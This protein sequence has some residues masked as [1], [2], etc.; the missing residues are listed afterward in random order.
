[1]AYRLSSQQAFHSCYTSL[2]EANCFR[3][4]FVKFFVYWALCTVKTWVD[5]MKTLW[6]KHPVWY[7]W[8]TQ[9]AAAANVLLSVYSLCTGVRPN[10]DPIFMCTFTIN[11]T[12]CNCYLNSNC[13]SALVHIFFNHPVQVYPLMG[14]PDPSVVSASQRF[15]NEHQGKYSQTSRILQQVFRIF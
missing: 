4:I 9:A 7:W 15:V 5:H 2:H 12:L 3:L 8:R 1:M 14:F 13:N 11:Q 10:T 6:L